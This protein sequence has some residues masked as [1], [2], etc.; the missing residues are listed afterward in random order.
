MKKQKSALIT[1]SLVVL[2]SIFFFFVPLKDI[3][4]NIPILKGFYQNTT[5]EITTPNGKANVKIN[6]KE[7]GETP[8]NIN[9]LVAGEY[10]VELTRTASSTD[11]YEPHIFDIE[12]TKN[13]ISRINIEIGPNDSLH[14]YILYYTDDNT[15]EKGQGKMTVTSNNEGAKIYIDKEL[16]Y[17]TPTTNISLGKGEYTI[18]LITPN[19][20]DLEFPILIREGSILN[21]KGYQLPIPVNF[22][23]VSNE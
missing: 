13:S 11:F 22:E 16:L 23:E 17:S 4:K 21:I 5:L 10:E 3:V 18:K 19:Y 12:L 7:Y 15:I 20:E 14:G 2:L 8:S 6:G 9:N 1:I